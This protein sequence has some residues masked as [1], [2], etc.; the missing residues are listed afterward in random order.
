[1]ENAKNFYSRKSPR[2]PWS[3]S[4]LILRARYLRKRIGRVA[5]DLFKAGAIDKTTL[6]E[7]LD[8]PM[9]DTVL[10]RLPKLEEAQAQMAQMQAQQEASKTEKNVALAKGPCRGS[11][12][13]RAL[14]LSLQIS[15]A[16]YY[17]NRA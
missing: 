3:K 15:L 13:L 1:M 11:R 14:A 9:I 8:P 17:P 5:G 16:P 4:L 12:R 10:A 7:M 6:V 2:L